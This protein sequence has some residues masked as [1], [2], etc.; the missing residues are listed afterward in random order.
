M[1]A[2]VGN[3]APAEYLFE[4]HPGVVLDVGRTSGHVSAPARDH[5]F[6]GVLGDG[7]DVTK[8]WNFRWRSIVSGAV[9]HELLSTTREVEIA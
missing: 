9:R 6:T 8:H 2:Y 5:G 3:D 7:A 4:G 1:V